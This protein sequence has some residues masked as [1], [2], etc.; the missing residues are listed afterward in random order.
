MPRIDPLSLLKCL[1]VLL[2]PNGGI[3]SKDEVVRVANLMSKFSKKLV[4]KCI[5]IQILKCTDPE[6]LNQFMSE[7]GWNLIHT[8][9][10]DGIKA[11]NWAL[12]QELLE[13]ILLCPVNIDRLKSND[14]PKLI[15]GLSKQEVHQNVRI[16]A[17][18]IVEQW[19]KMVKGEASSSNI[20]HLP[21]NPTSPIP[22]SSISQTNQ[23]LQFNASLLSVAS[24]QVD[25]ESAVTVQSSDSP[26]LTSSI[27]NSLIVQQT[28]K[29]S[30]QKS[31][32]PTYISVLDKQQTV[33]TSNST[34][35]VYRI[36][37]RDGKQ[38]LS[39]VHTDA[40]NINSISV[41]KINE[42]NGDVINNVLP[43]ED[44]KRDKNKKSF[45]ESELNNDSVSSQVNEID[46][47]LKN[48]DSE[49]AETTVIGLKSG[50][51]TDIVKNDDN[52]SI[53]DKEN[54]T[55]KDDKKGLDKKSSLSSSKS[56]S[57]HSSSSNKHGSSSHRSSSHRSASKSSSSSSSSKEKSSRDK[58]KHHS[59]S[60][61]GSSSSSSKSK[62]ER[63]KEK[64]KEKLKKD[65]AEKDK[66]T[67]EKLASQTLS[68]K[69]G[70]IPKKK[71]DE[72]K[73]GESPSRKSSTDSKDS[74][75]ENK[76]S[77]KITTIPEKKS[78]SISIENR[79]SSQDQTS[80]PKT[81]KTFNSKFR[82]TGLEEEV[83]PPP[84]RGAKKPNIV[85]DKKVLHSK[86][87]LK[88]PSPLKET[89][90]LDKKARFSLDSP[91][92]PPSDEKKGGIKLI[93][94]KPKLMFLQESDMFMDALT[95]S[96][97]SKEPR[98]RKRRTS[99]SK[100]DKP[101]SKKSDI[102]SGENNRD[103][104][105]PPA[106]P[107]SPSVTAQSA[108]KE[109]EDKSLIAMKPT[110]KFYQDTLETDEEK[111]E[112]KKIK[113]ED[114]AKEIDVDHEEI[115]KEKTD[116]TNKDR[117][118]TPTPENDFDDR[119]SSDS[120][121]DPAAAVSEALKK[122]EQAT[123][124]NKPIG[125]LKSVLLLQK[126]KGPKKSL[127]W[128]T[129]LE[130]IR[131]F[132]LDET[133]RVNVTKTFTDMKAME[134]MN[135]REAFQMARKL[136][137]ED[138]M[139]EKTVWK[140]LIP[141]DLPAPLVEPGKDSREKD[142]QYAREKGILQALYFHRS[143]IPDSAAEPD[144]ER[145]QIVIEP[146]VIPLDDLTGNKES[147]KDFSN[148]PWP[149][150]KPQLPAPSTI[151]QNSFFP[152]FRTNQQQ[153]QQMIPP[154]GAQPPLVSMVQPMMNS[155]NQV[156]P[157]MINNMQPTT[158]G[159][160]GWRTGD[161]KIV[162]VPDPAMTPMANMP[163]NYQGIDGTSMVPPNMMGAPP[164]MYNQEGYMMGSDDM[165][166][167]NF[168]GPPGPGMFG[169]PGPGGPP[170]SLGGPPGPHFQGGPRGPPMHG[171]RGR[172]A[173]NWFRGGPPRGMP[174]RG[175]GW[176]GSGKQPPVC[177]QFSK[178]GFCRVGDK[179]QFLHPGVNCP[180]PYH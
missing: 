42:I 139:E 30:P 70:K 26:D 50:D 162:S 49:V 128:K 33:S 88:R 98:K 57:K 110:F 112:T 9:L 111:V 178:N 97:K 7:N 91:T 56:S 140:P 122:E 149:E 143:M 58:D 4:S 109:A 38:V 14:C 65:Q 147:E 173:P 90:P 18:R 103:V 72:E 141:I 73:S 155:M 17:S 12:I 158:G 34:P 75:K 83:K 150:P 171:N 101:D 157:E 120:A 23:P 52:K 145:H 152:P 48:N 35:S 119:A 1:S 95:A 85:V 28:I 80:R 20:G 161:G 78:I 15:K 6:L 107:M 45:V 87:L 94:A 67:L 62:A 118:R 174:W 63:D 99:I 16:L 24:H 146:K 154:M 53:S 29:T 77:K 116:D 131:Y 129:D 176:R 164:H 59:S 160:G 148:V 60:S 76:E 137:S 127:K 84:P 126:R 153:T 21:A 92:T 135:E 124:E 163:A 86:L 102:N 47:V 165:G 166:F 114:D 81:V 5:Y 96:T 151:M 25:S 74:F 32:P 104:S 138:I 11:K 79:K 55:K 69:M 125:V 175:G 172:G 10:N 144:E 27:N 179:C 168:Q 169:P 136:N 61:K 2:G 51:E 159:G 54:H 41:N 121:E 134:K 64:E 132:E 170:G 117:S 36:I 130:S 115:G 177:R 93:P 46:P 100:D 8:W 108:T 3:K 113:S 71:A 82:S 123:V 66:A 44:E 31:Q 106:S 180:P 22:P 43:T 37:I 156:A 68:T 133:E 13:L 142:I 39:Q 19:L 105:S 40:S 89:G 167:N